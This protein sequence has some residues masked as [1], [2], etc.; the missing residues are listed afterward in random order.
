MLAKKGCLRD[1]NKTLS[2]ITLWTDFLDNTLYS[3]LIFIT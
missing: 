1:A 2:F 3:F